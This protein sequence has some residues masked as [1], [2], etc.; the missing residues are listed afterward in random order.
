MPE[1]SY[2]GHERR[3]SQ[4]RKVSERRE[5][6]RFEPS[7]DPRRKVLERR[8]YSVWDGRNAF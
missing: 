2:V 7:K 3:K 1:P 5:M 8:Q 6:I 4:R